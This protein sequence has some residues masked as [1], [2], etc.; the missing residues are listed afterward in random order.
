MHHRAQPP[1]VSCATCAT[2]ALGENAV[3]L[4]ASQSQR[5]GDRPHGKAGRPSRASAA[6][7]ASTQLRFRQ[8]SQQ[9]LAHRQHVLKGLRHVSAAHQAASSATRHLQPAAAVDS[10]TADRSVPSSSM[11]DEQVRDKIPTLGPLVLTVFGS[12]LL[13]CAL[14]HPVDCRSRSISGAVAPVL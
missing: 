13:T 3:S 10:S 6:V 14:R 12:K 4:F 5:S 2:W 8:Q 7:P 1:P 11:T 9:R